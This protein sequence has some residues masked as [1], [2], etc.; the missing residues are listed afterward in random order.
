M[1]DVLIE[2]LDL[3]GQVVSSVK[4]S[5]DGYYIVPAVGQGRYQLRVSPEQLKPFDLV[6]PGLRAVTVLPDGE[7]INGMDFLLTKNPDGTAPRLSAE[8]H[9]DKK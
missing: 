8:A 1:G 2:L 9:D 7:F 4:S 5:F 6:D 3:N